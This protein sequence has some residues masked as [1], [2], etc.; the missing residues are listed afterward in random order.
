MTLTQPGGQMPTPSAGD[1][2][3][4]EHRLPLRV[5]Y[6]DTDAGGVVYHANYLRFF[7]RARTELFP[8]IGIG[9]IAALANEGFT[10][11]VT[12]AEIHYRRG[13]KLGDVLT[14]SSS[15]AE[16]PRGARCVVKHRVIRDGEVLVE[17]RV[18]LALIGR[19]GRPRAQP[20][21]WIEAFAAVTGAE[22]QV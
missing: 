14:I 21:Q 2:H 8:L 10:Y 5:Y 3:D 11:V 16:K 4:G 9:E 15:L 17:A 1:I 7:E 22:S 18:S 13:A 19:D 20:K 6:E 12:N